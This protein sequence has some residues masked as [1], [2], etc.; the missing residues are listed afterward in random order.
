MGLRAAVG[1]RGLPYAAA[2][3]L[4]V[5]AVKSAMWPGLGSQ[6]IPTWRTVWVSVYLAPFL[7]GVHAYSCSAVGRGWRW[8]VLATVAGLQ[9]AAVVWVPFEN[10]DPHQ[11]LRAGAA[12]LTVWLLV[13][14]PDARADNR[15]VVGGSYSYGLYLVHVPLILLS[16]RLMEAAGVLVGTSL[17]VAL[18]GAVTLTVGL[19]FGRLDV[20]M[21]ARLKKAADRLVAA[22]GRVRRPSLL[23]TASTG[24]ITR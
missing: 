16:F 3:W 4:A 5:L 2:G 21:Y 20:A 15:L 12:G 19:T 11:W 8:L 6:S 1:L 22:A 14:F 24:R 17:G 9:L 13:Q 18:A 23:P 10:V 7:I